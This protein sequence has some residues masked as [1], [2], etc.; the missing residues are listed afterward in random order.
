M[1]PGWAG[2]VITVGRGVLIAVTPLVML[3]LLFQVFLLKLPLREV[4]AILKGTAFAT[5]GLFLFLM[6]V[7]IAFLPFGRQVGHVL[8]SMDATWLFV[9]V[10]GL[11]GFVTAWGEPA[12]RILA[13]QVEEA[14]NGSIPGRR[15]L[16]AACAGVAFWVGLG[17]LRI[18]Y[19]VP[20][21]YLLVPG[22]GLIIV[23]M[24]LSSSEFVGIA[25]DA[26]G[27]ATG[28]LA[29]TF[30]LALALG[31][32]SA[33]GTQSNALDGFGLLALIALA[34]V[35]SVLMLGLLVRLH[36]RKEGLRT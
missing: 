14:S 34:P 28:P 25:A 36:S 31:A 11:L 2:E 18:H 15:V 32:S 26:G 29:N 12:V 8:G 13:D 6:G 30:L 3:F 7:N 20:L 22:Y 5:V 1:T 21:M 17:V 9:V 16:I 33:T 19:G 27:V 35:M 10:G 24:W 4:S 23:L